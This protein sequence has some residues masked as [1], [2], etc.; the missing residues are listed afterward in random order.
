[1]KCWKC[2]ADLMDGQRFCG[3]CGA[4]QWERPRQSYEPPPSSGPS[5]TQWSPPQAG[6]QGGAS[7]LF[8]LFGLGCALCYGVPAAGNF[9]SILSVLLNLATGGWWHMGLLYTPLNLLRHLLLF[10]LAALACAASLLIALRRTPQNADGLFLCFAGGAVLRSLVNLLMTALVSAVGGYH[11]GRDLYSILGRLVLALLATG[12][13]AL[14]TVLNGEPAPLLHRSP[15]ELNASLRSAFAAAQD[16][17]AGLGNR[18]RDTSARTASYSV[19]APLKTNRSLV[20]YILLNILT[21]GFYGWYFLYKLAQD[22]NTTC[23]GDGRRTPGLAA[24]LLLSLVTCGFYSIYWY[25]C[26]GDRLAVNAPRY[27][28]TFQENG[29]T[30]LLWYLVG[31]LL[32]GIGPL[33]A[34]Y[35]I[36][37]NTNILCSAYNRYNNL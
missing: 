33:V 27:G 32:C 24:F 37:K 20:A 22:I 31:F 36:I 34:L 12:V 6:P 2:G 16:L 14:I 7:I 9:L 23:E 18:S 15:A 8:K 5:G 30:V 10:S 28:L 3:Q 26:V 21:C 19:Y 35:F 4:D 13:L 25:Y 17:A 29:T 1:M 11:I